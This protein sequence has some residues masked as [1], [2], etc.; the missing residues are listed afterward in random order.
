MP[1]FIY[2][3]VR[4]SGRL[5]GNLVP[6]RMHL[7]TKRQHF[8]KNVGKNFERTKVVRRLPAL[9]AMLPA[10]ELIVMFHRVKSAKIPQKSRFYCWHALRYLSFDR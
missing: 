6:G 3:L 1:G 8:P 10:P 7:Q 5:P 2:E 9:A 4:S